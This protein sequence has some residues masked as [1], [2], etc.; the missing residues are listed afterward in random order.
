MRIVVLLTRSVGCGSSVLNSMKT[1]SIL[2]LKKKSKSESYR[3][4]FSFVANRLLS[5]LDFILRLCLIFLCET[6][7]FELFPPFEC[8]F[9]TLQKK[10]QLVRPSVCPSFHLSIQSMTRKAIRVELNCDQNNRN[11][12]GKN[13]IKKTSEKKATNKSVWSIMSLTR[14]FYCFA[15]VVIFRF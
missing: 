11:N 5:W 7:K 6:M 14:Y 13:Y 1:F 10:R 12:E 9:R 4:C 2:N 8:V 3:I 15:I